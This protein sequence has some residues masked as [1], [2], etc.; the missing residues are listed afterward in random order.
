MAKYNYIVLGYNA[1]DYF[2]NWFDKSQFPNTQMG[3]VDNGNQEIPNVK[4]L[5]ELVGSRKS[6]DAQALPRPV[7]EIGSRSQ[8]AAGNNRKAQG[9]PIEQRAAALR[10]KLNDIQEVHDMIMAEKC[11]GD[12]VHCT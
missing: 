11:A 12:E 9:N 6:P 1:F 10:E 5:A 3:F 2:T 4:Q 7:R 8:G